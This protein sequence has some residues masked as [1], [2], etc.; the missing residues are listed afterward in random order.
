MLRTV[1]EGV[2]S[3][4]AEQAGAGGMEELSNLFAQPEQLRQLMPAKSDADA[5]AGLSPSFVQ[6]WKAVDTVE[7]LAAF[8]FAAVSVQRP[9][10][11][12]LAEFLRVGMLLREQAGIDMLERGLKLPAISKSQEQLRNYALQALRRTQQRLL[13]EVLEASRATGDMQAAVRE[14]TAAM[15][16]SGGYVQP[17]DLEQAMLAVWSLS[18]GSSPDRLAV[19]NAAASVATLA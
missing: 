13:L 6:A 12:S 5:Q 15:G 2:L 16:L 19:G 8:L 1:I 4:P 9:Q 10:G 7:S 14:L 11:M 18:E 17:T 3:L